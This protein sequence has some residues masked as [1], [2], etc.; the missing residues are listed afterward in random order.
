MYNINIIYSFINSF[1]HIYIYVIYIYMYIYLF[2]TEKPQ[3]CH[4]CDLRGP[5]STTR[6]GCH[7]A[8]D[9]FSDP[10]KASLFT[11]STE[12]KAGTAQILSVSYRRKFASLTPRECTVH[13][14]KQLTIK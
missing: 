11:A 3:V 6:H 5:A 4:H 10:Q 14:V 7:V 2:I 8:E 13:N 12:L 9:T 1:I